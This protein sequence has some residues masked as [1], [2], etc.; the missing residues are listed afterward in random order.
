MVREV[1]QSGEKAKNARKE[2]AQSS[3]EIRSDRR[4]IRHT[5][6]ISNEDVMTGMTTEGIWLG[7]KPIREMTKEIEEMTLGILNNK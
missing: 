3:S 2:I 7:I 6:K 1:E 5:G 4:E